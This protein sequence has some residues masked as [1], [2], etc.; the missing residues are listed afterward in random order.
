MGSKATYRKGVLSRL[1]FSHDR[2]KTGIIGG[3]NNKDSCRPAQ[4]IRSLRCVVT[5]LCFIA[6]FTKANDFC[7]FLD[8]VA[9][10]QRGIFS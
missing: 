4:S 5:P 10:P 2:R 7:N 9:L 3:M 1:N 8:D 6:S